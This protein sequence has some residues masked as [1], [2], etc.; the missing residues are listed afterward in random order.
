[1]ENFHNKI[2]IKKFLLGKE[3][4]FPEL[5]SLLLTYYKYVNHFF[6]CHFELIT[7]FPF[8]C[9]MYQAEIFKENIDM[10]KTILKHIY[11][12]ILGRQV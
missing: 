4:M 1:M 10:E 5:T 11:M 8:L 7:V 2:Y 9:S 6:K 12:Y 3:K